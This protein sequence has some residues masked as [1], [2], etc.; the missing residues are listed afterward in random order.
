M[1]PNSNIKLSGPAKC[2]KA[3]NCSVLVWVLGESAKV[4]NSFGLDM[5][6]RIAPG[7]LKPTL[8]HKSSRKGPLIVVNFCPFCGTKRK[9]Q[10]D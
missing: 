3:K 10:E 1:G 9:W 8:V 4:K 2:S 6:F 5:S 7:D